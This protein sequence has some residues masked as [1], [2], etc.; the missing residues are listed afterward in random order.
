MSFRSTVTGLH[1]GRAIAINLKT[2]LFSICIGV[3][4]NGRDFIHVSDGDERAHLQRTAGH[5]AEAEPSGGSGFVSRPVR[6]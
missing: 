1:D 6:L 3:A 5:F 2:R 4:G